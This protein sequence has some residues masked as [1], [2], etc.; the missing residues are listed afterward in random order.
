MASTKQ[1]KLVLQE[2]F[3]GCNFRFN[4]LTYSDLQWFDGDI[5]KPT[6]AEIETL[7]PEVIQEI[8]SNLYKDVRADK[9]PSIE[10]LVVALW[11]KLVETDGLSSSLIDDIQSR[12]NQVK[13]QNPKDL[14]TRQNEV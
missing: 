3:K 13:T 6:E 4:G 8:T 11:E 5:E 7:W 9:Y 1:I 10:E 12:R 2:K 14:G